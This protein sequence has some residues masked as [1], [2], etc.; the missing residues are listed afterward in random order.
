M[1]QY[2]NCILFLLLISQQLLSQQ[3]PYGGAP[4]PIPG[5]IEAENYDLGGEG[6]AYHDLDAANQGGQYRLTEGVDIETTSE[7]GYNV[8][9]MSTDEWIEYTVRVVSAGKYTIRLRVASDLTGGAISFSFNDQAVTPV[10]TVPNTG[11][12]QQWV[13]LEIT[14]VQLDTG[15][16]VMRMN[17]NNT[18]Y[19][20]N[21]MSFIKEINTDYPSVTLTSPVHGNEHT[22][23]E[24]IKISADASDADGVVKKVE[25][26]CNQQL[27]ATDTIAP[28]ET[29][30]FLGLVGAFQFVA[31]ATDDVG[32]STTSDTAEIFVTTAG[33][34]ESPFYSLPHGFYS[35]PFNLT[36]SFD[37]VG[38]TIRYTLDG[39]DPR[40]SPNA[41]ETASPAIININPES[42]TGRAATPGVVVRAYAKLNGIAATDVGSQTYIFID[43]VK[44][45]QYPGSPWPQGVVNTKILDYDMD[46]DVVNDARYTNLIDDALLEIPTVCIN[47]ELANLFDPATGIYVNPTGRG[48]EW[49]RPAAIELFDPKGREPGFQI[50][51]GIRLRGGYSRIPEL[52][53]GQPKHAFRFFFRKDYGKGKLD[54]PLFGNEGVSKFDGVDLRTAQNYS[55]SYRGSPI[56]IFIRDVFSRDAQRDMGQPYTRTRP[57]HLYINGMYW[58]LYQTQERSEASFAES[59]FGGN[60]DDYDV[61][62]VDPTRGGLE[63][64]DGTLNAYRQ[65]RAY[66]ATGFASNE[67]YFKIQGKNPDGSKNPSYPVLADIGNLIDYQLIIFYT[68]NFDAPI[69][70]FMG[71]QGV[72]NFYAL[73]NR[74]G[75]AGFKFF[76]HD[77]EHTLMDPNHSEHW[78]YGLDRTGPYNFGSG[79]NN[80]NPQWFHERLSANAEYRVLFSDHVYKHFFNNGALTPAASQQRLL[81][82]SY[83]IDTAVIA[84][85]ARWGD[86]KVHPPRTKDDDWVPAIS[87]LINNYFPTRTQIV[88]QQLKADNLYPA[89]DPPVFYHSTAEIKNNIFNLSSGNTV[90]LKNNNALQ[91]GSIYYTLDGSD[92]RAI[93]GAVRSS[94]S[95]GGDETEIV[96][97][98]SV[99]LKARVKDG[100]TWSALHETILNTGDYLSGVK[101]TEIH[102]NPLPEGAIS[103]NEFEFLEF[104]NVGTSPVMLDGAYFID[105]IGYTFPNGTIIEPD[106]FVVLASNAAMFQ[107][108]YGFAP[109]GEYSG[110]LDNAGERVTLVSNTNDTLFTVRY[111]DKAPWPIE[112]DG[113]GYSIVAKNMNGYGNPDSAGYWRASLNIHGSPNSD[114]IVT[115]V[116]NKPK[117]FL[118][119]EFS[120]SQNYP[121]P[122]NPITTI[123][124]QL[125]VNS[126]ISLKVY[127][128]LGREVETLVN[129]VKDAGYYSVNFNAAKL[130][131]GV[132]F[133]RIETNNGFAK[134]M[135]LVLL[136]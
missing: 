24:Q 118:P 125:P 40:T 106:S 91:T 119:S 133:Y 14:G 79:E 101:V 104:K 53:A 50:N 26:F 5:N 49:E 64:T 19:N 70:A 60:K 113:G 110:Q 31:V 46:P 62:K 35:S 32:A 21:Y 78:D 80:F 66:A 29:T 108:R 18:G 48:R 87:W 27:I 88:L 103:G 76:Q 96:V 69:S 82:R 13:W 67:N 42:T 47:T 116:K 123:K 92:P 36:V 100:S 107:Q 63:A 57:Y 38:S 8:G 114:D 59:Y 117:D 37:S 83:E 1:R 22:L 39:S 134:T 136:K 51:A 111:N 17:I 11:G 23:G 54:Y 120:L 61:I 132:Y 74:N 93:G 97:S 68:G 65:L 2:K 126:R 121:N 4:W 127:D 77:A 86:S 20:V 102:Y 94:A 33:L 52:Q 131:S 135:K 15:V 58:G 73:Y 34:P 43:K 98:A 89:I 124:Y 6:V 7:G 105:G 112:A 9:W 99:V 90:V 10:T 44:T 81:N 71:N 115:G 84:E 75:S 3:T 30:W 28:Y 130:S 45:Q 55:W 85:S 12:W 72:N 25:F 122:F 16:Q 95:D 56:S 41:V 109:F 128:I 129:E